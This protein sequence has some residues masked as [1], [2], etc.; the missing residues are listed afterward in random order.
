M[1]RK[2]YLEILSTSDKNYVARQHACLKD[3]RNLKKDIFKTFKMLSKDF[4]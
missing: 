1:T 3:L 4:K 2:N